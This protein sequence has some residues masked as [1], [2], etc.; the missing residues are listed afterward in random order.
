MADVIV[1]NES[2]TRDLRIDNISRDE[3]RQVIEAGMAAVFGAQLPADF[4]LDADDAL[5]IHAVGVAGVDVIYNRANNWGYR[6]NI[7]ETD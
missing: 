4:E 7:T 6:I 2:R 3:L 1:L 5:T